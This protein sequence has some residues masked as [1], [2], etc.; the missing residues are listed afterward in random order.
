MLDKKHIALVQKFLGTMMDDARAQG[1]HHD[2][3]KASRD[4]HD[5][6]NLPRHHLLVTDDESITVID[7]LEA[8]ADNLAGGE[9]YGDDIRFP[10][11]EKHSGL[12]LIIEN[13][14]R[15]YQPTARIS[16][17]STR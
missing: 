6:N 2:E 7:L 1:R 13:T 8:I 16:W 15:K 14:I 10:I 3:D 9:E 11:S 17:V 5:E 12:K 4:K